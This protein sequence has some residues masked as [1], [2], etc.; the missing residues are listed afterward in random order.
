MSPSRWNDERII[1]FAQPRRRLDQRVEHRLQI[2]GRAADDLEH[3]GGGGLL[4]Q[5]FGQI[6]GARLHLVEQPHVLDRD[7]RL[8][9]E[10]AQ[11]CDLPFRE[12]V[13]VGSNDRDCADRLPLAEHGYRQ[14][15]PIAGRLGQFC[16][17]V[18][19]HRARRPKCSRRSSSIRRG[20]LHPYGSVFLGRSGALH[21]LL[22][23]RVKL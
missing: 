21:R 1:G 2:E 12:G 13:R 19:G 14:D 17:V 9:G 22:Q 16:M 20:P 15:A 11:Q 18:G 8:V 4:L 10:G 5:R 3:V 6:V 7:H 23:N